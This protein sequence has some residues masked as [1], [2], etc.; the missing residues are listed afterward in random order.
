MDVV[1]P[2]FRAFVRAFYADDVVGVCE[3]MLREPF[4]IE[5]DFNARGVVTRSLGW[6]NAKKVRQLLDLL[7][8]HGLV[9]I[10]KDSEVRVDLE[11][12]NLLPRSQKRRFYFIDF[13]H[14]VKV[15]TL[16]I[17]Q[18]KQFILKAQRESVSDI[19]YCNKCERSYD[20]LDAAILEMNPKT[21]VFVC[22]TCKS[23]LTLQ[24]THSNTLPTGLVEKFSKQMEGE[25]DQRDSIADFLKRAHSLGDRLPQNDPLIK[26]KKI[27]REITA[28][29][30]AESKNQQE[31][32]N[33]LSQQEQNG[34]GLQ[35]DTALMDW[36]RTNQEGELTDA[37]IIDQKHRESKRMRNSANNDNKDKDADLEEYL[38]RRQQEKLNQ[39]AAQEEEER[40]QAEHAK[41]E[42]QV[43]GQAIVE[44]EDIFTYSDGTKRTFLEITNQWSESFSSCPIVDLDRLVEF[45]NKER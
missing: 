44:E 6:I 41:N 33:Y 39:V 16:R 11:T 42:E 34:S 23:D 2:L 21:G 13:V 18:I 35:Q 9:Q 4:F 10:T 26:V 12:K 31:E 22:P 29:N 30:Q 36:F 8:N 3:P 7:V 24:Q 19:W 1:V 25:V 45:V 17:Y 14:F 43:S 15:A 40:L 27:E 20:E 5:D 32:S 28:R 38:A 37:A